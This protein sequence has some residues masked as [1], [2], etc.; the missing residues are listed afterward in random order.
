MS[1]K[2]LHW[3]KDNHSER[4]KVFS[5]YFEVQPEAYSGCSHTKYEV[6]YRPYNCDSALLGYAENIDKCKEIAQSHW[7]MLISHWVAEQDKNTQ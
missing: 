7:A 5:G 3:F 6:L 2:N 1:I 4:A